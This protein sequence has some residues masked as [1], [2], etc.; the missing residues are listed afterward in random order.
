MEILEKVCRSRHVYSSTSRVVPMKDRCGVK[1]L[2]DISPSN[3]CTCSESNDNGVDF[4]VW[5]VAEVKTYNW[6]ANFSEPAT[7]LAKRFQLDP[8]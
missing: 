6:H 5:T 3:N 4:S 8:V 2:D 1:S 7:D